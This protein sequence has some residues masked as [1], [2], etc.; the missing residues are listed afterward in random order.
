MKGRGGMATSQK[1]WMCDIRFVNSVGTLVR[2]R[3]VENPS[4][5]I[6]RH[7]RNTA[8]SDVVTTTTA[9]T[10]ILVRGITPTITILV[11]HTHAMPVITG[12]VCGA[13]ALAMSGLSVT[14][15]TRREPLTR[16]VR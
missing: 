5:D 2:T 3:T 7:I 9:M 4:L 6:L 13:I 16:T 15:P 11:L 12:R 14:T 1:R 10:V 8:S